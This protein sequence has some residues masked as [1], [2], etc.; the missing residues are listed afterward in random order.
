M[1]SQDKFWSIMGFF[2]LVFL[3]FSTVFIARGCDGDRVIKK[4][5]IE[6]C[7]LVP[8]QDQAACLREVDK[9]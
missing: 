2:G 9:K 4:Q 5:R 7:A 8:P 1:D 6:A 3:C